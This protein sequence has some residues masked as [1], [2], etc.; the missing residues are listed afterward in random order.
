MTPHTGCSCF[1]IEWSAPIV[2]GY[3]YIGLDKIIQFFKLAKKRGELPAGEGFQA[4][5]PC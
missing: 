5:T 1:G 2:G 4:Y 3:L